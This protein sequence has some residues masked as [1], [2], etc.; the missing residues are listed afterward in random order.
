MARGDYLPHYEEHEIT[1]PVDLCD[2]KGRLNADAIG[3]SRTP[4]VR[5]N[6]SRHWP[7]KKRWNFWNWISDRFVL[8][9]TLADIDY[10]S[11]CSVSFTDFETKETDSGISIRRPHSFTMPEQVERTVTFEVGGLHYSNVNEGGDLK[12]DFQGKTGSGKEITADFV[13]RKPSGHE[14]LNVVVPWTDERFQLNSKHNTLPCE[15]TLTVGDKRYGMDPEECHAVQDFGRGMWPHRSFWNW[16]VCTGVQDGALIGVNVGA[17]WTT[18]TG[19]NENGICFNGRLYKIMEDLAWT[20]DP[21]DW[22]KP[23]RVRSEHSKMVELTL[24]PIVVH[25]P[26]TSLGII[27]SRGACAFGRW[28]GIVRFDGQTIEIHDLIGWAEEFQ[29][30]W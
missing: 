17:R 25:T 29:H 28:R 13:V 12:V 18:G 7:R 6:L 26:K 20:Y 19:A 23:W 1:E 16:G 15:G 30:R 22:S 4:L 27:D 21:G 3:W 24:D 8:T 11:F 5:A 2:A 14:S 9:I 10:A